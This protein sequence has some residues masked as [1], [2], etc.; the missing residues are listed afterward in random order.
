MGWKAPADAASKIVRPPGTSAD[1]LQVSVERAAA[2]LLTADAIIF[3]CGAGMGVDSGIP[4]FRGTENALFASFKGKSKMTYEQMSNSEHFKQDPAFAWGL[5]IAQLELYRSAQPHDGFA[6]MLKWTT[7][8]GKPWFAFT[9]NIDAQL[10]KAGFADRQIVAC[11]GDLRYLQCSEPGCA[12]GNRPAGCA[13]AVWKHSIP[14]GIEVDAETLRLTRPEFL[15]ERKMR[16]P[17]CGSVARPNVWFCHDRGY[18]QSDYGREKARNLERWLSAMRDGKRKVAVLE[19]GAG[20]AIPTVRL[21]SEEIVAQ[22]GHGSVLVRVN[23]S[24]KDCS[25]PFLVANRFVGV[26]LGAR[27]ALERIDDKLVELLGAE[28]MTC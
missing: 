10:E 11:H 5:N 8:L 21:K 23:P 26:P 17:R 6:R 25:A 7:L 4:D 13:P 2:A 1:D 18:V 16:C 9:S 27:D 14:S 20:L 3:C 28:A 19:L 24:L 12:R 15:D 22:S